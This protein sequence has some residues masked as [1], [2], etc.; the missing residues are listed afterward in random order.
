LKRKKSLKFNIFVDRDGNGLDAGDEVRV[1]DHVRMTV[2]QL[3]KSECPTSD[4]SDFTETTTGSTSLRYATT[5]FIYNWQTPKKAGNC[6]SVTMT[7]DE[8]PSI[9]AKFRLR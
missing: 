2:A 8:G 1:V 5:E 7:Y 3:A 4:E 9:T 6:Y